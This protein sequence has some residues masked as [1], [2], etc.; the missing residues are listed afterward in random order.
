[1]CTSAA[2]EAPNIQALTVPPVGKRTD[3]ALDSL[4]PSAPPAP[5]APLL[6]GCSRLSSKNA[7]MV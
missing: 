1:M 7:R 3:V 6:S 2:T 4:V 5:E